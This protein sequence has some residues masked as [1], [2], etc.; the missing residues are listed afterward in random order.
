[1]KISLCF[2][3]NQPAVLCK[4][5]MIFEMFTNL[6]PTRRPCFEALTGPTEICITIPTLMGDD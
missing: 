4:Y 3:T 5:F 6:K 1:M 2:D